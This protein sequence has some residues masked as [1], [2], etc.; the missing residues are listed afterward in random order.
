MDIFKA[1][2]N[3][4]WDKA[5]PGVMRVK[6]ME[7]LDRMRH[8]FPRMWGRDK[9]ERNVQASLFQVEIA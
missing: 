9:I 7:E 4:I 5:T 2:W 8:R 3:E 6:G 1:F